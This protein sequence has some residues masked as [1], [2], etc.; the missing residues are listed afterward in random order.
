LNIV[1]D[2]KISVVVNNRPDGLAARID[3]V[4]LEFIAA[5]SWA[6]HEFLGA[7]EI[8]IYCVNPIASGVHSGNTN[9]TVAEVNV[10]STGSLSECET[11]RYFG[12]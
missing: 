3:S 1:S 7:A 2:C 5:L 4:G 9:A 11:K 6:N 12:S 8:H 10:F